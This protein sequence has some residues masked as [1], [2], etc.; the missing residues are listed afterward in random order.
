MQL[1]DAI[2]LGLTQGLT[3]FLPVSSSGHLILVGQLLNF[4][5][6]N[7][8]FDAALNIGTLLALLL[9]FAKDFW[10]LGHDFVVGGPKRKLAIYVILATIPAAIG[11]ALLQHLIEGAFRSP[12]LIAINLIWVGIVMW[13]VDKWSRR[14]RDLEAV[15]LPRALA[16][17]LAQVAAVVPGISRSGSTITTARAL[18][19]DRVTA[20]RFSFWMAAPITAGATVKALSEGQSIAQMAAVPSLYIAGIL[21]AFVSGYLAARFVLRYLTRHGLAVFAFYRI[22]LGVLILL[23]GWK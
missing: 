16:V 8:G 14:D 13:Q 3:E 12:Q 7:L 6:S 1:L 11:G 4:Q 15:T 5:Y 23:V 9:V 17:G 10:E 2:I 22:A 20:V 21:A 18:G 19:F